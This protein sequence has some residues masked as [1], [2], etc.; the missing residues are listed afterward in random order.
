MDI[1]S[2]QATGTEGA[3]FVYRRIGEFACEDIAYIKRL[4]DGIWLPSL[5]GSQDALGKVEGHGQGRN[6]VEV[7]DNDEMEV[8]CRQE[9]RWRVK[10]KWRITLQRLNPTIEI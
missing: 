2:L 7:E 10:N 4:R 1:L 5:A 6:E 3:G 8:E 9:K